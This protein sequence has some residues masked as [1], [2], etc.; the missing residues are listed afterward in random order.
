MCVAR[1]PNAHTAVVFQDVAFC[2]LKDVV[3][4]PASLF[5]CC[6]YLL[7]ISNMQDVSDFALGVREKWLGSWDWIGIGITG[8][9]ESLLC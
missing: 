4:L 2:S 7:R 9:V 8:D 6:S 1:G 5:L 3:L